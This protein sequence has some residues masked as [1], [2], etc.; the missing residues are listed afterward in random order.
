MPPPRR[1]A[2]PDV[3][4]VAG[5][6]RLDLKTVVL[7]GALLLAWFDTTQES[8]AQGEENRAE[9]AQLR[10]EVQE[11]EKARVAVAAAQSESQQIKQDALVKA[12][13]EL[14][15]QLKMT[16][17]DIADLRVSVAE[18]GGQSRNRANNN[19]G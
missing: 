10:T 16:S 3:D 1:P 4:L 2:S 15:K 6:F 19:G 7:L 11:Q 12:L 5:G 14:E 13:E 17:L 9:L 18:S 8:K